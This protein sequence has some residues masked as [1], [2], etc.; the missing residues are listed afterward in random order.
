MVIIFKAGQLEKPN[1]SE[2]VGDCVVDKRLFDPTGR[3]V[4]PC[5][6]KF[7]VEAAVIYW[8]CFEAS[9][10]GYQGCE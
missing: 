10:S 1:P 9:L 7:E 4:A 3:M 8:Q 5:G 6:A 2:A